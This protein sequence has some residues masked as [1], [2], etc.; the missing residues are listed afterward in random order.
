MTPAL[1]A[2]AGLI[3]PDARRDGCPKSMTYGPC[4]GVAADGTCELGDRACVFLGDG[5]AVA[6]T[7]GPPTN[8]GANDP[9]L[10]LVRVRPIVVVDLPDRPLDSEST[11]RAASAL[12]GVVDAALFGDTGCGQ[13]ATPADLPRRRSW[14]ARGCARG[15]V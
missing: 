2:S 9:L 5:G 10:A 1:A 7:G 13:G 8:A 4:G 12:A 3:G 11:R 14:P 15:P 6:W